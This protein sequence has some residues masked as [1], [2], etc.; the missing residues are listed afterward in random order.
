MVLLDEDMGRTVS[1]ICA[2]F[3]FALLA[4]NSGMKSVLRLQRQLGVSCGQK[5][6]RLHSIWVN[7]KAWV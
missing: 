2:A 7:L 3:H 4:K 5:I 6:E 1:Y